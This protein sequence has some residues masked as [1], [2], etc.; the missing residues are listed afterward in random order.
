VNDLSPPDD[1]PFLSVVVPTFNEERRIAQTLEAAAMF[2]RAQSWSWEIVVADDGSTDRTAAFVTAVSTREP[3]IRLLTLAHGGKGSAVQHGML[4]SRGRL[5]YLADA[6]FSTPV[7]EVTNL[8][9]AI[10]HGADLAI[11]SR[12]AGGACRIGEPFHRHLMGRVFNWLIQWLLLP[13]IEDTQCGFKCLRGPVADDLFTRLST[14]G[15]AFDVE[16]LAH[17]RH[18]GYRTVEVPV[19][20]FYVPGGKVRMVRDTLH[21]F[22]DLLRIRR[23][24]RR[25]YGRLFDRP[26]AAPPAQVSAC[27]DAIG[28][29]R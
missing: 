1:V 12:E 11:A 21:M 20:W 24:T 4:E 5:R 8:L 25:T 3:R 10:E 29:G 15:F 13:G 18:R 2:L 16:V 19:T 23:L 26:D 6:D 28:S 17:A 27:R 14:T 7:T 22:G 9:A